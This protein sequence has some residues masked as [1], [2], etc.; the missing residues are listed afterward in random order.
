MMKDNM[1][2]YKLLQDFQKECYICGSK[3]SHLCPECHKTHYIPNK[4][5]ILKRLNYSRPQERS[6]LYNRRK[7]RYKCLKNL[8][9]T[10][11]MAIKKNKNLEDN[12][13]NTD[14]SSDDDNLHISVPFIRA[15]QRKNTKIEVKY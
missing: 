3:N 7:S 11:F 13:S 5:F 9:L 6:L 10:Q 12:K 8:K 2:N 14:N 1:K 15:V 4:D